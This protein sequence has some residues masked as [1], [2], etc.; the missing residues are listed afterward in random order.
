MR[1][2]ETHG[3]QGGAHA[4]YARAG[5]SV[6]GVD[7]NT[8]HA[9]YYPGELI[10][11]DAA[12]YIA[13]HGHEYDAIHA[14]PPCQY[15]TRGNAARRAAGTSKWP[16]SIPAIRVALESTCRPY[17]LE[18]VEDAAWDML[19]PVTLCGCM[20]GL[21]TLDA[22]GMP[23]RLERPRLFETNWLLEAPGPCDHSGR[24]WVAGVY[25]GS[26]RAR[27][28]AGETLAQVAPR[29][30][31]AAK[32]IRKGG[33]VPR[34]PAVLKALLGLDHRMTLQGM[35]ECLPPAYTNFIGTQL[36]V[37]LNAEVAA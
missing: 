32:Y 26:R 37:H 19:S 7:I 1:L 3:C 25:G 27:R 17:V 6:T 16:R 18:N 30:R 31:Y 9:K 4:G 11:A 29:D 13:A 28:R 12:E 2:L 35:K 15:Y 33:Y 23:L 20:F 34:D 21:S 14:S 8:A 22:D 5:W 24:A 10:I 36:L